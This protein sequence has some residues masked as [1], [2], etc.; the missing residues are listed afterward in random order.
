MTLEQEIEA[1]K[2]Q[3]AKLQ[4]ELEMLENCIGDDP[5]GHG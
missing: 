4:A 1:V 5:D 3:I 2:Q